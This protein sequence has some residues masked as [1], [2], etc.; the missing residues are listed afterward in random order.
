MTRRRF[1][2]LATFAALVLTGAAE[3]PAREAADPI[4]LTWIEGDVAGYSRILT[5]DAKKTLGTVEYHQYRKGD[6]LETV[7][8]ARFTDGSSDEDRAT[9]RVGKTL[10]TIGGRSI[11]RDTHGKPIVDLTID[12]ASGHVTGFSGVGKD[13]ET[14][15]QHEK[16]SPGTYFGPLIAIVAK[17]F[18]ANA[19]GDKMVFQTVVAT[20]KPRV[21]DMELTRKA[22]TALA[23]PGG[24][25]NVTPIGML[26]T[27][28]FLLDPII[29]SLAPETTFFM[30]TGK[31]PAL[32]RF[33]GPRNYAGQKIVIE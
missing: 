27:V 15:D 5:P 25:V 28:N 8:V 17:N 33:A 29:Q 6:V 18:E 14:Y 32:V 1:R 20:P 11:I 4:T 21:L 30:Q 7:R 12:V 10:E 24:R 13:R 31:P 9:A 16:L 26:P 19:I 23:K 3:A 2:W 22:A